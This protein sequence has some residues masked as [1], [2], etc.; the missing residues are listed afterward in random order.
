MAQL[1]TIIIIT[2]SGEAGSMLSLIMLGIIP[3]TNIQITFGVW[4]TAVALIA[5][6]STAL[7]AYRHRAALAV[8]IAKSLSLLTRSFRTI[9]RPA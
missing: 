5:F 3:G 4:L 8:F 1:Y 2:L 6:A 9:V 7:A